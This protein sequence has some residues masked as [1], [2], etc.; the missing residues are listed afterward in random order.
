MTFARASSTA[1]TMDRT[2]PCENP[3]EVAISPTAART[4]QSI[5][6]SLSK[7]SFSTKLLLFK[8]AKPSAL[9]VYLVEGETWK[10]RGLPAKALRWAAE[11]REA[12]ASHEHVVVR[13]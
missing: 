3:T 7:D 8:R 2:S 12:L 13:Q 11:K 5:L 10:D 4:T 1:S 6:G 9:A